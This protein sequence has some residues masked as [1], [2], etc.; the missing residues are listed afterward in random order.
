MLWIISSLFP[1][2]ARKKYS[3]LDKEA[4][5]KVF[6]VTRF[7]LYGRDFV[8]YTDHKTFTHIFN[9]S[10]SIPRM[11]SSRIQHWSLTLGA[12][13][14]FI[15]HCPGKKG[16]SLLLM[17]EPP[18]SLRFPSDCSCL[19]QHS[20]DN[21]T[22]VCQLMQIK[23]KTVF[24]EIQFFREFEGSYYMDSLS[25]KL[26]ASSHRGSRVIVLPSF[27]LFLIKELHQAHHEIIEMKI[28]RVQELMLSWKMKWGSVIPVNQNRR[29]LLSHLLT[30]GSSL[31]NCVHI[32][33][34]SLFMERY[35]CYSMP[36][37][38]RLISTCLLPHF[39]NRL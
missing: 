31:W 8:L 34:A 7:H 26:T 11:A 15:V 4:V 19:W 18:P 29:A 2:P 37:A 20:N 10:R 17:P 30:H 6:G 32:D 23:S 28:C 3:Q 16:I 38:S 21:V 24:P 35:F 36:T 39:H 25:L 33:Y 5:A 22:I 14:Y 27:R 13:C 1:F 12:Y 9:P